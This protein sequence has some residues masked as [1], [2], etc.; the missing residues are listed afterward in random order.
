MS[1]LV[2]STGAVIGAGAAWWAWRAQRV[3]RISRERLNADVANY[4]ERHAVTLQP[5][6]RRHHAVPLMIGVGVALLLRFVLRLDLVYCVSIATIVATLA[7]IVEGQIAQRRSALLETQLATA[8]DLMVGA[9]NG[10]AGLT[11]AIDSA[12]SESKEPLKTELSEVLGRIRLGES[13]QQVF[14]D[15]ALRIPLEPFRI[16]SFTLA[17]HSEVGG[18][19]A[20][21]LS[22]VGRSIRDRIEISRRIRAQSTEAQASVVGVLVVIYFLGL[23]MWRTNPEKFEEY[24]RH[25]VGQNFVAGAIVLQAI[26]MLWITRIAKVRF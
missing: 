25:P 16:L 10:G 8:I 2:Y 3:R 4:E 23:L 12:A 19:L 26:G 17:V 15:F 21:T 13:P 5:S 20:P 11:E 24:L 9:L 14:E 7:S 18:S 1:E 22:T 6:L